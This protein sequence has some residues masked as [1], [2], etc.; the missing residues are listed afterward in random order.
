MKFIVGI[1]INSQSAAYTIIAT[2]ANKCIYHPATDA[3]NR[4]FTIPSN[5]SLPFT[6]WTTISFMNDSANAVTIAIT[7]DTLQLAWTG[8][9]GSRTLAQY[10]TATAVKV[11]STKRNISWINIT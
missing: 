2:D 11:T 3:N 9:T 10:G 1:P 6:I 7:T 4:T 8:S 5:S